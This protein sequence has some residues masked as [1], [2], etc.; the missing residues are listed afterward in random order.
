[1]FFTN[2]CLKCALDSGKTWGHSPEHLSA[3][4]LTHTEVVHAAVSK[5]RD[6]FGLVRPPLL[7]SRCI[8]VL[9]TSENTEQK[10]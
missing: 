4:G 7:L 2:D 3:C 9:H 6:E 8:Q 10:N 5:D 1:M